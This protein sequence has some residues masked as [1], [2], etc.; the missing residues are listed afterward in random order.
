MD[1]ITNSALVQHNTLCS[2][3]VDHNF[4]VDDASEELSEKRKS[5]GMNSSKVRRFVCF[6]VC[7]LAG[8]ESTSESTSSYNTVYFRDVW[9]TTLD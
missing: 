8:L 9:V 1:N 7:F 3:K 4:S 5:A 2:K 6:Y